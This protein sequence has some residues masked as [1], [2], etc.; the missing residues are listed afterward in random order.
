MNSNIITALILSIV[1]FVLSIT[2]DSAIEA[3]ILLLTGKSISFIM[4]KSLVQKN[5]MSFFDMAIIFIF[6]YF[7]LLLSEKKV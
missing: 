4:V 7:V 1:L 6:S 5:I 2:A 3:S